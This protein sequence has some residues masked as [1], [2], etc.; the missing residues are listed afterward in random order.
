MTYQNQI[1]RLY[2]REIITLNLSQFEEIDLSLPSCNTSCH[3]IIEALLLVFRGKEFYKH[4]G[5]LKDDKFQRHA[6]ALR[7][8][9]TLQDG[10]TLEAVRYFVGRGAGLTP[11]GDDLLTGFLI[12][13]K[14]YA[15]SEAFEFILYQVGFH[16]TT[17]VSEAYL[18]AAMNG[19]ISYPVKGMLEASMSRDVDQ[20]KFWIDQIS[21]LGHTSGYDLLLGI[22]YG[23]EHIQ[24]RI[25]HG[26]S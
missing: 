7:Q 13:L 11:S 22:K 20:I 9:R 21:A 5:I 25:K 19:Y 24:R 17:A 18:H 12:A 26:T 2:G 23:L 6:D 8:S 3:D 4:I 14:W 1:L 15:C 10:Q 16:Q